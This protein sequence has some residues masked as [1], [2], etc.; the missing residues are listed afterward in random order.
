MDGAATALA[1]DIVI[2]TN[3]HARIGIYSSRAE[4]EKLGR[5]CKV[6]K[7]ERKCHVRKRVNCNGESNRDAQEEREIKTGKRNPQ[8]NTA[9][10]PGGTEVGEEH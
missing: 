3:T 1:A 8:E 10:Q 9:V 7:D 5:R 2:E 6:G 4:G